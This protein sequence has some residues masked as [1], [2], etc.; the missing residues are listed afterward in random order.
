M[1]AFHPI[2]SES[3]NVWPTRPDIFC[4][5]AFVAAAPRSDPLLDRA[6]LSNY[7][8]CFKCHTWKLSLSSLHFEVVRAAKKPSARMGFQPAQ[9]AVSISAPSPEN[10]TYFL[11]FAVPGCPQRCNC[12]GVQLNPTGLWEPAKQTLQGRSGNDKSA[13]AWVGRGLS[14]SFRR[15]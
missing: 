3:R 13:S 14:S 15:G 9:A 8:I 7:S 1:Q 10:H 4:S 12:L 6:A 11:G 2:E 5:R